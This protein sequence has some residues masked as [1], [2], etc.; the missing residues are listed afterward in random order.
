MFDLGTS[1]VQFTQLTFELWI[2]FE[3]SEL[4][5][6]RYS[7]HRYELKIDSLTCET[8]SSTAVGGSLPLLTI[9]E[10]VLMVDD[11]FELNNLKTTTKKKASRYHPSNS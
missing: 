10:P 5:Q 9:L 3:F 7:M 2:A 1:D 8:S 11:E 4:L 6:R